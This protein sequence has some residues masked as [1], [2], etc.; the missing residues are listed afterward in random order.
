MS[1]TAR[2]HPGLIRA[3]RERRG[4]TQVELAVRAGFSERLVRKAESGDPIRMDTVEALAEVLSTEA[5]PLQARDLIDDPLAVA[6]AF[7][8]AY[9]THGIDCAR[10]WAHL[11]DPNIVMAIHSDP[12]HLGFAGEHV[13]IA[14]IEHVIRTALVQFTVVR[15]DFGRWFTNGSRVAALRQQVLRINGVPDSPELETWQ[16]HEYTIEGGKVLRVD[17]YLDAG[18]Y[19]RLLDFATAD[20]DRAAEQLPAP[21]KPPR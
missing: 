15:E 10:L 5:E 8:R 1:T 11:F 14:G 7:V 16:L 4:W 20:A 21:L 13:G 3:Y 18:V 6:Q 2:C 19:R 9:L 12:A 17:T